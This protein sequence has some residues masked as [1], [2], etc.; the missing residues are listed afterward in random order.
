MHGYEL[1]DFIERFMQTCVDLKK[2]TAYFLLDKMAKG[3]LVTE[4]EAQ[5]GN[6]PP[7]RVYRITPAG[8]R[9]FQELLRDNLAVYHP[10]QF[11][12]LV[13]LVFLDEISAEEAR[14]LLAQR[15][16]ALLTALDT[17]RQVPPHPGSMQY[18]IAHQMMHLEQEL[19]WLDSILATLEE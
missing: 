6:R 8:E 5:S 4:T 17:V 2:S 12:G 9:R 7:R 11:G 19:N 18:V 10:A 1:H 16:A 13:G 14:P 3:G 15:R